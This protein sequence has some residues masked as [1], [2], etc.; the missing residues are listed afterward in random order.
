LLLVLLVNVHS[1]IEIDPVGGLVCLPT[2]VVPVPLIFP[3]RSVKVTATFNVP[4]A[5]LETSIPLI[6]KLP[7]DHNILVHVILS[8]PL[9]ILYFMIA[10]LS[11]EAQDPM[12]VTLCCA[13]A[14]MI[15]LLFS[16]IFV[17]VVGA[18]ESLVIVT[19]EEAELILPAASF[20]LATKIFIHSA[21]LTLI[22]NEP[23]D[24]VVPTILV[25]L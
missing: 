2:V 13:A 6:M 11:A 17:G 10:P 5:K 19:E 21:R 7:C 20:A 12:S 25:Q 1:C 24:V 8:A 22:E 18:R 9:T 4:S 3:A 15:L 16:L 23:L 14:L